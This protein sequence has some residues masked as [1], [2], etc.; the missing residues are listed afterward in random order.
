VSSI[1]D[2]FLPAAEDRLGEL[3]TGAGYRP[4]PKVVAAHLHDTASMVGAGLLAQDLR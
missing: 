4:M 2:L 1:A 3:V